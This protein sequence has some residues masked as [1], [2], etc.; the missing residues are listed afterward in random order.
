MNNSE[1]DSIINRIQAEGPKIN[2]IPTSFGACPQCGLIHPP[3]NPG[4]RC[5]NAPI[6]ASGISDSEATQFLINLKNI[7]I[8]NIEKKNIKDNKKLFQKLILNVADFLEKYK[9]E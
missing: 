6:K 9:E 3:V 2:T 5:P 1:Y 7:I 4:E 8:S